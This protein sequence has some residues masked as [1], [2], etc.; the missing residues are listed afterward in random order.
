MPSKP[1]VRA[2]RRDSTGCVWLLNKTV[3]YIRP[4]WRWARSECRLRDMFDD[5]HLKELTPAQAKKLNAARLKAAR[6]KG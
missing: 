3:M 4:S 2:W 6:R 5:K 1:K